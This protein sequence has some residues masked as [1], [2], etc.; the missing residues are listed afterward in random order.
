MHMLRKLTRDD[1]TINLEVD[2]DD[3]PVRGNLVCSD[4]PELDK[5]D[6]DEVFRRLGRGDVWAWALVKVTAKWNGF[7]AVTYLGGCTYDN[8]EQFMESGGYYEDMI[9]EALEDLN[10]Q[11]QESYREACKLIEN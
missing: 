10:A 5:R 2:Y 7:R 9:D 11:V 8:E 3:T 6:E 4:E 1:V